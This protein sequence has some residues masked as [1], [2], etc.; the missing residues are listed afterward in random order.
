MSA[1]VTVRKA[2]KWKMAIND[3]SHE[4]N[5]TWEEIDKILLGRKAIKSKWVIKIKKGTDGQIENTK[6]DL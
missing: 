4:I 6:Q 2:G 5:K 1:P 3:E